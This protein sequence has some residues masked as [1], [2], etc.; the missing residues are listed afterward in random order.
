MLIDFLFRAGFESLWTQTARV[1]EEAEEVKRSACVVY[2]SR[3]QARLDNRLCK[4][5]AISDSTAESSM[6]AGMV[7]AWSSAIFFIVP[8]KVLPD[9]VLGRRFTTIAI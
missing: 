2:V 1:S 7:Q 5:A 3:L 9:R 4:A 8:R 6:V